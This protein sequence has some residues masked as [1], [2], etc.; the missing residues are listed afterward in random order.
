MSENVLSETV[1][2]KIDTLS[3]FSAF[4]TF[5]EPFFLEAMLFRLTERTRD[6]VEVGLDGPD[7][8]SASDRWESFDG[9]VGLESILH[10]ETV[11]AEIYLRT[12]F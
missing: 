6:A 2:R 4:G 9:D 3:T 7:L 11:S 12:K 8:G 10:I 5:R 1:I